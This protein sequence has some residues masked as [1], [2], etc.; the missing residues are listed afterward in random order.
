VKPLAKELG[1]NHKT[2]RAAL[3]LL[4]EE[5]LLV[6][7][8]LGLQRRIALPPDHA[9]PALRVAILD[10]ESRHELDGYMNEL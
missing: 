6:D 5:G 7:Q 3:R 4:E 1:V 8:G 9:P 2:V 10:Y